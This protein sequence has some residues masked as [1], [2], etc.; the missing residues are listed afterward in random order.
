LIERKTKNHSQEMKLQT[1]FPLYYQ[2]VVGD[3]ADIEAKLKRETLPEKI[4][5]LEGGKIKLGKIK[6]DL[7]RTEKELG[8]ARRRGAESLKEKYQLEEDSL[9][10][11]AN[12]KQLEAIEQLKLIGKLSSNFLDF[13]TST[14]PFDLEKAEATF[15]ASSISLSKDQVEVAAHDLDSVTKAIEKLIPKD[16]PLKIAIIREYICTI[17][18]KRPSLQKLGESVKVTRQ[19]A[20]KQS[21][22]MEKVLEGLLEDP[23]CKALKDFFVDQN[24]QESKDNP[25]AKISELPHKESFKNFPDVIDVIKIGIWLTSGT[26]GQRPGFKRSED[27]SLELRN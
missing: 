27:G 13:F 23:S 21:K 26:R 9:I 22:K 2:K 11:K 7:E 20:Q 15:R 10:L 24:L 19:A 17:E 14:E 16:D 12:E 3:L 6:E 18:K 1:R 8:Q 25:F 4:E 5:K